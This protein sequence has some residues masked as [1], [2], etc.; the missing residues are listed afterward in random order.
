MRA[1]RKDFGTATMPSSTKIVF[2]IHGFLGQQEDWDLI[3][4][5]VPPGWRLRTVNLWTSDLD[6]EKWAERFCASVKSNFPDASAKVLVGYSLGGRLAL[7]ALANSPSL[8]DGAVIISAN[9]GLTNDNER[10]A[11]RDAD[12]KWSVRFLSGD[13]STLMLD[14]NSQ[15][16]LRPPGTRTQDAITISRDEADFDRPA[17]SRSLVSWSLGVQRDLRPVLPTL[18]IP[19]LFVTGATDSKFSLLAK[20]LA[21]R[22]ASG[23]REHVIVA[24][25]GHRVPWDAPTQFRSL[26]AK[27]LSRW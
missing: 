15:D 17:L 5:L 2:A 21:E 22:S 19:I 24:N 6:L 16:V 7:H 11:R 14:W 18:K 23:E 12:S 27:F 8:F 13:W 20:D 4:D 26:L 25:A 9:P 3:P 1:Q 10:A